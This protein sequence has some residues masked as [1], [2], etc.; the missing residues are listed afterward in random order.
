VKLFEERRRSA[1]LGA[2]DI[3]VYI[4]GNRGDKF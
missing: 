3:A 4:V 1:Q 2:F